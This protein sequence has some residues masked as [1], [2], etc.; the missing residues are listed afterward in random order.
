[1]PNSYISNTPAVLQCCTAILHLCIEITKLM[2]MVG[3]LPPLLLMYKPKLKVR[4]VRTK[5]N[6]QNSRFSRMFL[7]LLQLT[8]FLC[9]SDDL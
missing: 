2:C 1:M 6:K 3:I 5:C 8:E 7:H 4:Y 9:N